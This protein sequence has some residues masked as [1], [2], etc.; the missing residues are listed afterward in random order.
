M[1]FGETEHGG[2][3]Q[4]HNALG[5]FQKG[6]L[7]YHT[8]SYKSRPFRCARRTIANIVVV[9][10]SGKQFSDPVD[11]ATEATLKRVV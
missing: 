8:R 10:L 4:H 7:K 5:P 1:R 9:R 6:S 2:S 3:G 11:D